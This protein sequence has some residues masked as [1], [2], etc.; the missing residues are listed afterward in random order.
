MVTLRL[1]LIQ[2]DTKRAFVLSAFEET[3]ILRNCRLLAYFF[4]PIADHA[5]GIDRM[6]LASWGISD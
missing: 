2:L 4:M 1:Q 6:K 5:N 3:R